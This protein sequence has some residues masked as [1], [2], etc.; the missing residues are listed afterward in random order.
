MREGRGFE[1]RSFEGLSKVGTWAPA[2]ETF[3][4]S[5]LEEELSLKDWFLKFAF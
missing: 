1:R 4:F 3:P 2:S 5:S